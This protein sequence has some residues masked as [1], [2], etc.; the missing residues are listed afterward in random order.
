MAPP[1]R[2][3]RRA[4][5]ARLRHVDD[6]ER[7]ARA[8]SK[9]PSAVASAEHHPGVPIGGPVAHH[10]GDHR[11]ALVGRDPPHRPRAWPLR[12]SRASSERP[13]RRPAARRTA[14]RGDRPIC[15]ASRARARGG[16]RRRRAACGRASASDWRR[17]RASGRRPGSRASSRRWRARRSRRRPRRSRRAPSP[18][19]GGRCGSRAARGRR[20]SRPAPKI[21]LARRGAARWRSAPSCVAPQPDSMSRPTRIHP[22]GRPSAASARASR[23]S[24]SST[25]SG[26]STLGNTIPSSGKAPDRRQLAIRHSRAY[27]SR[28]V[29]S[30]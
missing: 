4:T 13:P 22:S 7:R 14:A 25:S 27:R 23:S 8:G 2:R 10:A 12:T 1:S 6:A 20:C 16:H 17:R 18:R 19:G 15:R 24:R 29:V 26:C 11:R 3:R 21:R 9:R 5:S 28:T 30:G